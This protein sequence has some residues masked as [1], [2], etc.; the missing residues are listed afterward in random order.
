[1]GTFP[2]WFKQVAGMLWIGGMSAARPFCCHPCVSHVSERLSAMS[3]G[4][5][6]QA[7]A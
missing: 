4:L 2:C 7:P 3:Y 1:M 6:R 5:S